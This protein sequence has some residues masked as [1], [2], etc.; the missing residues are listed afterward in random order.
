MNDWTLQEVNKN[1]CEIIEAKQIVPIPPG[2]PT[3]VT[4]ELGD[5]CP[6][7][8]NKVALEAPL[9]ASSNGGRPETATKEQPPL[10]SSKT[11][12]SIALPYTIH[13]PSHMVRNVQVDGRKFTTKE[14][15]TILADGMSL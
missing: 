11:A 13:H 1:V 6:G 2:D 9:N 10:I 14:L 8:E 5:P 12:S 7:S 3:L 15:A 4:L